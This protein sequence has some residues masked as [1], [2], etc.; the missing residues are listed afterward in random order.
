MKYFDLQG[1]HLLFFTYYSKFFVKIKAV[2]L[3]VHQHGNVSL[4]ARS[5][6]AA[7]GKRRKEG[8]IF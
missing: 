2:F 6:R 8:V 1:T 5:H 7:Q 3:L 4:A